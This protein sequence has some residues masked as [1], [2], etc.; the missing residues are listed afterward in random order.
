M[1]IEVAGRSGEFHYRRGWTAGTGRCV[2][3]C[4][5]ACL[6]RIRG[7][8]V[9]SWP[10]PNWEP[11][12]RR[13]A[14]TCSRRMSASRRS[15]VGG[16]PVYVARKLPCSPVS[17]STTTRDSNRV[18]NGTP[19]RRS[20]TLSPAH[21]LS[22]PTC[23]STCSV[24]PDW[25]RH[26]PLRCGRPWTIPFGNFSHPGHIHPRSSSTA[27]WMFSRTMSSPVHST[28]ASSASTISCA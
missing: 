18:A 17:A 21:S 19:L 1:R 23:A 14:G 24:L 4:T 10:P 25:L 22:T 11:S 28:A 12:S 6:Y 15:R 27:G 13:D 5:R 20:S 3:G 2:P 8:S 16:S 26:R 9:V 7:A